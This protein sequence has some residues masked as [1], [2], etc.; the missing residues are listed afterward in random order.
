M[1]I[2]TAFS[3]QRAVQ[4][5]QNN[6]VEI[7][8]LQTQ[9]GTGKKLLRPSDGPTESARSVDLNQAISRLDQFE[10]NRSFANQKLGL[11]DATLTSVNNVLQRVRD[12]TIQA[13]SSGQTNETRNIIKTEIQQRLNEL[14]DYGNTRDGGGDFLFAG[15]KG[16]TQPFALT[17]SGTVYNGDQS[18]LNLQ[19]SSN[20]TIDVGESGYELFQNIRNGNGS[21]LADL[22]AA[23]LG[24]GII[25]AGGVV[26]ISSYQPHDFNIVF[27]SPTTFDVVNTTT[28]TTILSA[29]PYTS[30]AAI[31]FNGVQVEISGNVQTGDQFT[32]EASRNQDIFQTLT[33]LVNTLGVSPSDPA[34]EA[35][36]QQGLQ[37]A[38]GDIDQAIGNVLSKRTSVGTRQNSLDSADQESES[39]KLSLQQTLSDVED[40]DLTDAISRLTF[41]ITTLEAVQATF[42]KVTQLSLFNF[43]R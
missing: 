34:S 14:L 30:G 13:N 28:A 12:L 25:S 22:N 17:A 26:D 3:F 10:R 7:G 15:S 43:L 9:I 38:L 1:R 20:R 24:G 32:V 35:Q 11:V 37:R 16:K 4:D 27:T 8:K 18:P 5:V 6:L 40:L 21:F 42:A 31:N 23:N 33:N 2:S 36:L 19:I 29:Q 39:T 41:E